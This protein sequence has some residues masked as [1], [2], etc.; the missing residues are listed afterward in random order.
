MRP[1]IYFFGEVQSKIRCQTYTNE[2]LNYDK[3]IWQFKIHYFFVVCLSEFL[4][5]KII[6]LPLLQ[7]VL[8]D[9]IVLFYSLGNLVF[10]LLEKL[11]SIWDISWLEF[12]FFQHISPA[13]RSFY[14]DRLLVLEE[15][16][17]LR[18]KSCHHVSKFTTEHN[19]LGAKL[20]F[21]LRKCIY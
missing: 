10:L 8:W 9:R 20:I 21:A 2:T 15:C 14:F 4:K 12:Y 3:H 16:F 1:Y 5:E 18:W 7:I 13:T 11:F 19:S 17:L 6:L